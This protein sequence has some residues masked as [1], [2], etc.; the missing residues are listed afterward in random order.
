M[1]HIRFENHFLYLWTLAVWDLFEYIYHPIQSANKNNY[2]LP[3]TMFLK[4]TMWNSTSVTSLTK[5]IRPPVTTD[6]TT[7]NFPQT[8]VIK[9]RK[10]C[11]AMSQKVYVFE[12]YD[13]VHQLDDGCTQAQ[14]QM[15]SQMK[16]IDRFPKERGKKPSSAGGLVSAFRFPFRRCPT[17]KFTSISM[18]K[19][20]VFVGHAFCWPQAKTPLRYL[21]S[22]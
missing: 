11:M 22:K 2:T 1:Q 19:N 6:L 16:F 10:K 4:L 18:S 14:L 8:G 5:N 17:P 21:W 20:L 15:I 3:W 9:I 13:V 7:S 12:S